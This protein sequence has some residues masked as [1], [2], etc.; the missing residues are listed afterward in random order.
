MNPLPPK[1]VS[2]NTRVKFVCKDQCGL[3]LT[4]THAAY[5][6]FRHDAYVYKR[7]PTE[8]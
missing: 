1:E 6:V 8:Q 3:T 2:Q 7:E 5:A 4:V